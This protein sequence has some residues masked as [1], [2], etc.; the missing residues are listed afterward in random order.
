MRIMTK[1]TPDS[2]TAS[3]SISSCHLE[4][5]IPNDISF[6]SAKLTTSSKE[7]PLGVVDDPPPEDG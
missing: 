7:V 5:S 2:F 1:E 6:S 3:Q 4:T